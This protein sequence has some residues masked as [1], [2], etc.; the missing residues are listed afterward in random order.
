[1]TSRGARRMV[2]L[3][4]AQCYPVIR[5]CLQICFLVAA[6]CS[7]VRPGAPA[8]QSH[9]SAGAQSL[10][11]ARRAARS[12]VSSAAGSGGSRAADSS[13]PKSASEAATPPSAGMPPASMPMI[14]AMAQAGR[15]AAADAAV[16]EPARPL[17]RGPYFASGAWHGYFWIAQHGAGTTV[18]PTGF[19]AAMF[20]TPICIRGTVVATADDSGN[21]I[22]GVNLNQSNTSDMTVQSVAPAADGVSLAITN[23]AGSP[24]RVQVQALD[25]S[26]NE[27]AR[28]CANLTGSGGFVPWTAFN[29]ACWDGTGAPYRGEPLSG[30]MLLVPGARSAPTPFD[31]CIVSLAE[32]R[33]PAAPAAGSG[34]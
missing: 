11:E 25:G 23:A 1:L 12:A 30:A 10:D 6:G 5:A 21:A 7:T 13:A 27:R 4:R 14:A 24:V 33:A 31:V 22:L 28:W 20:A 29:T 26:T 15:D 18:A 8:A 9:A 17:D 34:S 19:D 3:A 2:E 16:A 32:A